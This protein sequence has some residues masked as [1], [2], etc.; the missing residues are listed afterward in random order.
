MN[1]DGMAQGNAA[2]AYIGA[3]NVTYATQ[4]IEP[5]RTTITSYGYDVAK[6]ASRLYGLNAELIQTLDTI[7]GAR[8]A[9][10]ADAS[11]NPQPGTLAGLFETSLSD[12][13][14]QITLLEEAVK[15][16]R[17]TIGNL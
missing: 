15:E 5:E 10:I 2:R 14:Y 9:A 11:K 6:A 7:R 17:N 12:L 1:P 13:H 3:A 8:P 16:I 4:R